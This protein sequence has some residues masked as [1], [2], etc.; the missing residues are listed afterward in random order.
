VYFVETGVASVLWG[1]EPI[2]VAMIGHEGVAGIAGV[3]SRNGME[4]PYE[5]RVLI[6]GTGRRV[7]VRYL[8]QAMET[9]DTL[10]AVLL[11]C[12]NDFI[13]QLGNTA[14]AHATCS[15]EKRLARWLLMV[16]DRMGEQA[17]RTTHE[18]LPPSSGSV[19]RG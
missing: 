9:S 15:V 4:V 6:A 12:A 7:S 2:E 13:N 11:G 16:D 3:L 19:A 14:F 10:T 17:L 5:T 8:R 1:A 18:L